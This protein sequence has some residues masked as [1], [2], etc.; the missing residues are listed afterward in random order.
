LQNN[1]KLLHL[2]LLVLLT[3][4]IYANSLNN[5]FIYDDILLIAENNFI[6]DWK[7]FSKLFGKD[8][9]SLFKEVSYRPVCTLTY[10]VDYSLWKLNVLGWHLTNISFHIA[11]AILIYLVT[12]LLT[13]DYAERTADFAEKTSSPRHPVTH[14]P[15]SI[16]LLTALFFAVHPIQ[17][18]AVN[19]IS[20]REDLISFFFFF[21]AF[22]L[23]VKSQ[24][25]VNLSRNHLL[26]ISRASAICYL[27]SVICYLFAL[28]SKEMAVT[29]P[30]VLLLYGLCFGSL[31]KQF[32][33]NLSDSLVRSLPYFLIAGLYLLGRFTIF[34]SPGILGLYAGHPGYPGGNLY[35]AMLTTVKVF[36]Y[37]IKLFF[38]P[39]HLSIHYEFPV[40]ESI[41]EGTVIL[42]LLILVLIL[43]ASIFSYRSFPSFCF[44]VIYFFVVL[45][46]V[47]NIV[48]LGLVIQERYLYFSCFGFC[49]FLAII[50]AKVAELTQR[51]QRTSLQISR[52]FCGLAVFSVLVFYSLRTITRNCD[53]KDDLTL[54]S[55]VL[56]V[57]PES[58][59]ANFVLG[60][61]YVRQGDKEKAIICYKN[62]L[63]FEPF[64]MN[65][66]KAFN[67]LG[68]I[69]KAEKNYEQ[70]I[71]VF[72]AGLNINPHSAEVRLN[73]GNLY[74][75]QKLFEEAKREFMKVI[76]SSPYLVEAYTSLATIYL[77]LGEYSE[78]SKTLQKIKEIDPSNPLL[79]RM[80]LFEYQQNEKK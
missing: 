7:N 80:K 58:G 56:R 53:W 33:K 2:G 11:N 57:Y 5:K 67:N 44:S 46:P 1:Y 32:K 8:Y 6:K 3:F 31:G 16:P 25:P 12:F 79:E 71:A 48:P 60:N 50:I 72:K 14:S 76:R 42:S 52:I 21:L 64:S 77:L 62:V 9:F 74:A 69:Y 43:L 4:F 68:L 10:F 65:A 34:R 29:L 24:T 35:T 78:G 17:T 70:A 30:L 38:L 41:F 47:S 54:W 15:S 73:L 36:T 18:E 45:L 39:L 28:F 63:K 23:Y 59:M 66:V 40:A 55:K 75:E 20:F 13:A 22:Y 27:T 19:G 51:A 61:E 49:L 37:S 26:T